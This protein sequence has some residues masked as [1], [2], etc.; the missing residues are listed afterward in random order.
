MLKG[1]RKLHTHDIKG[2]FK[3]C[4]WSFRKA[5]SSKAMGFYEIVSKTVATP[6]L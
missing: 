4:V 2:P 6:S 3:L 1:K 5:I